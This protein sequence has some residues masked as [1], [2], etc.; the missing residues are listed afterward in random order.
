MDTSQTLIVNVA[1]QDRRFIHTFGANAP[2]SAGDIPAERVPLCRVLYLGGYLLMGKVGPEELARV[3]AAARAAGV[4]TVLDVVTPAGMSATEFQARLAP[5]LPVTD[6]FVPNDHEAA[7]ITGLAD[8]GAG[9]AI[10]TQGERGSVLVSAGLHLRSGAY[11]M[12]FVD[13]T[14]GGD[15]FTAGYIAG[16]LRGLDAH[17]RVHP[18]GVRGVPGCQHVTGRTGVTRPC[19]PLALSLPTP[20]PFCS[21]STS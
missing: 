3:F 21:P 12:P 17:G 19:R 5:V 6:V 10:I 1:G 4:R 8:P 11:P 20:W 13:G 18:G 9:T 14:G 7:L 15:A 2:F 16:M